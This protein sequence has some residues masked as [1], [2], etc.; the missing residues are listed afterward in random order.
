MGAWGTGVFQDDTAADIRE[1]YRD[2][3]GNGLSGPE[4]TARILQGYASSLADAEGAGVVWLALAATQWQCGR[5]E[6]ETLEKALRVIDSGSDLARWKAGSNGDYLKR[7]AV[8]EKLRAQ[9]TSPQPEPK[10]IRRRVLAECDWRVGELVSY[11]LLSG[12]LIVFRAIGLHADKGGTSPTVELLDWSGETSPSVD[13][14]RSTPIRK[15]K[16]KFGT[17]VTR[18][19][20]VGPNTKFKDRLRRLDTTLPA[21]QTKLAPAAVVL[22]KQLDGKL[23]DWF[24]FR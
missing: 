18:L 2:H 12:N 9:I 15:G 3:I 23:A 6:P 16:T 13:R 24:G 21:E 17:A 4:S 22:W 14:L 8:L 11:R 10:K 7:R 19:L 20:V 5:L 1:E